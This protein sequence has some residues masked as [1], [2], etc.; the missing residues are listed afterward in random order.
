MNE[1]WS[2]RRT[3]LA[4]G[5]SLLWLLPIGGAGAQTPAVSVGVFPDH[6][7]AAGRSF[8]DL[9]ALEDAIAPMR[10]ERVQLTACGDGT[11]RALRAAA[12][13][14]RNASLELRTAARGDAACEPGSAARAVR[15]SQIAGPRPT[16]IHDEA[17]DRWWNG[18]QP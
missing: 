6:Y 2:L 12:H 10:P 16:G 11:A 13:R 9:N 3:I 14:F 4:A 15:V 17:V 8:D 7:V 18:M 5:G 1:S